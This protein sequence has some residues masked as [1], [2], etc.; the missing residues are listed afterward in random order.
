MNRIIKEKIEENQES[1]NLEILHLKEEQGLEVLEIRQLKGE[2]VL[3]VLE[4]LLLRESQEPEVI[5]THLLKEVQEPEVLEILLPKEVQEPEVLK[6]LLPIKNLDP[7]PIEILLPKGNL[8]N[9]N[10]IIKTTETAKVLEDDHLMPEVRA[11]PVSLLENRTEIVLHERIISKKMAT[12]EV[13]TIRVSPTMKAAVVRMCLNY[14][15]VQKIKS[16]I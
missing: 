15:V 10:Q 2:Q 16:N 11:A 5:E 1:V 12:N 13:I 4:I 3:A 9:L 14:V 7:E 8:V 6:I